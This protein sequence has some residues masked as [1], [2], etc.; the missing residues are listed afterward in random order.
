MTRP[1]VPSGVGEYFLPNNLT[2]SEAIKV[3]QQAL[4]S[5]AKSV[6]M[7]YHPALLAQAN[8][9]FLKRNYNL[10]YEVQPSVLVLEPDRLGG[11]RWEEWVSEPIE[12]NSLDRRPLSDAR[13]HPLEAPFSDSKTLKA[14]ESDF[15]DWIY[16]E[17]KVTV[18]ANESL[19]IYAGPQIPGT[20]FMEMA[21]D[22][23]KE[24]RDAEIE[25]TEKSF[26]KKIDTIKDR[27]KREERELR[28]DETELSQRKLE[29]FGT[30]A[31]TV[32]SLFTGRR[33]KI[34]TSLS[35][36]RM[37]SSAKADVE[38]S[39]DSIENYKR[40]IES[41]EKEKAESLEEIKQ[42]WDGV[43]AEVSEIPVTPYK[44]DIL[45]KLF[46]IAWFPY[47]LVES[48]GR[49]LELPAYRNQ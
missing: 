10:D 22:A 18:L 9:R 49:T 6:G 20:E 36:R 43:A 24:K 34:T 29:E 45:V 30:H 37:T 42:K 23:A 4:P 28:E 14:M 1:N 26:D 40:Q 21:N 16:Y 17:Q 31:E 27:L 15:A 11:V 32:L 39:E 47:H 25:K 5:D 33:R 13:Y 46:G 8:V 3:S 2:F 35:K 41:L 19:K 7:I 12:I 38:E 48:S 44:K